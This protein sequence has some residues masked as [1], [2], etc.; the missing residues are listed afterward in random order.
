MDYSPDREAA[1]DISSTGRKRLTPPAKS[2]LSLQKLEEPQKL[3][4]SPTM[5]Q[6][7]WFR[8]ILVREVTVTMTVETGTREADN[9]HALT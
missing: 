3:H 5:D 1:P 8:P 2:H 9:M 7:S 4:Q 6:S